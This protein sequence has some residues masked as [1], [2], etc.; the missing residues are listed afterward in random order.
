M[1]TRRTATVTM[2][3]P[4]ASCA[5]AITPWDEYFPVPTIRRDEK[6]RPAITRVSIALPYSSSA[7]LISRRLELFATGRE[8]VIRDKGDTH[9]MATSDSLIEVTAGRIRVHLHSDASQLS[10]AVR[11]PVTARLSYDT[12]GW[13]TIGNPWNLIVN[14]APSG[15]LEYSDNDARFILNADLDN[16]LV[17][18][19]NKVELVGAVWP[20]SKG[21]LLLLERGKRDRGQRR[22]H[23]VGQ[24]PAQHHPPDVDAGFFGL[25][26]PE[27]PEAWS[28]KAQSQS[29]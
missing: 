11:S 7:G 27:A 3:A 25:P 13:N 26:K 10:V 17:A 21:G 8:N 14:G 22:V 29:A 23:L 2:S 19:K 9:L 28:P 12:G 1:F 5:C 18:G 16:K 24:R 4:D 6:E 20:Q 15:V